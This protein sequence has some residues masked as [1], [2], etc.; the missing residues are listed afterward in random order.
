MSFLVLGGAP[1]VVDAVVTRLVAD[2]DLVRVVAT[3]EGRTESLRKLGAFVATGDLSDADL[4]ERAAQGARTA[5]I[6]DPGPVTAKLLDAMLAARISRVIY[7][8]R[9]RGAIQLI[10]SRP[11][12]HVILR[13]SRN[14]LR[15]PSELAAIVT[16]VVAADDLAGTP[17]TTID[18]SNKNALEELRGS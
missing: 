12:D 11:M 18:L 2:G 6:L 8:G 5:V 13:R 9:D 17:R 7:A 4:V 15:R 1:D 10:G 16:A 14:P 3:D